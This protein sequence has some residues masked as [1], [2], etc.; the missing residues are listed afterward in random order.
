MGTDSRGTQLFA[1]QCM[2]AFR[3]SWDYL[4]R[5]TLLGMLISMIFGREKGQERKHAIFQMLLFQESTIVQNRQAKAHQTQCCQCICCVR[6]CVCTA[7]DVRCPQII[8]V[9]YYLSSRSHQGRIH[10]HFKFG[11]PV[12]HAKSGELSEWNASIRL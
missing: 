9:V 4:E 7:E 5:G 6:L 1:I 3:D 12:F 8:A 10:L 11:E 2:I